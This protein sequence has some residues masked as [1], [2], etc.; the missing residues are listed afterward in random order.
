MLRWGILSTGTI[1]VKFANTLTQMKDEAILAAVASRTIEKAETFAKA[2]SIPKAYGSYEELLRDPDVDVVY[3]ATPNHLHY[4][5]IRECILHHKHVLCE[6]P[7]TTDARQA[8][9]LFTLAGKEGVFL[10]EGMWISHLPLL[11]KLKELLASEL[12]GEVKHL[13]AD[14][15]FVSKGA[16]RTRKFESS[17]GGGAL[18]DV[19][20]YNLAF[21]HM[22]LGDPLSFQSK[23]T[24]SEFGTDDF[25]AIL[26]EYPDGKTAAITTAI[27]IAMPTEGVI[28]GE[29]G[30]IFF[31]NYQHAQSLTVEIYGEAP[32][33]IDMLFEH[34]GFEYQIRETDRCVAAGLLTSPYQTAEDTL[35]VLRTMDAVRESWGMRFS[36]E[37]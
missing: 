31:P 6:K 5:N 30:R 19:G 20:V 16:R 17:L 3:I 36:F 10:M 34:T 21:A 9:E 13:R 7:M 14:Y 18:L 8:E 24:F 27:G 25:S 22:V 15:G 28:Y 4:E 1:A 26:L 35:A 32:Y 23:V 33:T 2:H 29:K 37:K 11:K 12:I